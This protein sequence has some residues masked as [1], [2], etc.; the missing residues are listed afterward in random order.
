MYVLLIL[1]HALLHLFLA[2]VGIHAP[3]G[4][5]PGHIKHPGKAVQP[6]LGLAGVALRQRHAHL[7]G[8][9]HHL[10][11]YQADAHQQKGGHH[12]QRGDAQHDA[13]QRPAL[14]LFHALSPSFPPGRARPLHSTLQC[15]TVPGFSPVSASHTRRVSEMGLPV[16]PGRDAVH[17]FEGPGKMQRVCV[18]HHGADG[19]HR[20]GGLL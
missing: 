4:I 10:V 20:L 7:L 5:H 15:T 17:R 13:V 16:G 9:A 6:A 14:L 11:P 12:H 19:A 8:V 3:D 1:G 18:A 2:H